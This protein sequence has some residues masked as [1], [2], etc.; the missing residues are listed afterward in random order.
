MADA[1]YDDKAA[2]IIHSLRQLHWHLNADEWSF[3][4]RGCGRAASSLVAE[5]RARLIIVPSSR[6]DMEMLE[7]FRAPKFE[8]F[9]LEQGLKGYPGQTVLEYLDLQDS[10]E[11]RKFME[12][13]QK[14]Q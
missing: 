1:V 5:M 2:V 3:F 12:A 4:I 9:A 8:D 6:G 10:E 13:L 11:G 7:V 14:G